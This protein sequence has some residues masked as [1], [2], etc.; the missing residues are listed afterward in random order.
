M[1]NLIR[2]FFRNKRRNFKNNFLYKLNNYYEVFFKEKKNKKM[3]YSQFGEDIE[4][5]NYLKDIDQNRVYVDVGAFHPFK[6]NNTKLLHDIGWRGYNFDLHQRSIDLFEIARPND[7]NRCVGI[8]DREGKKKIN[9]SNFI[10]EMNSIN[11]D[12]SKIIDDNTEIKEVILS[13]LE[14]QVKEQFSFLNIDAEGEDLKIIKSI[15]FEKNFPKLICV[16]I[17]NNS[18]KDE[19]FHILK[20]NNYIFYKNF[21][22]S[23]LFKKI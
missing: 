15:D 19:F 12:N 6:Y 17:L 8:S 14:V 4:I 13:T 7:Y 22:V 23:Y 10:H 18:E 16:E 1:V 9:L 21:E 2:N 3:S 20:K 11:I 5:F